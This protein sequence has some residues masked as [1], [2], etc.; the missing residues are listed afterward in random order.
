[1]QRRPLVVAHRGGAL[2]APEN[3]LHAFRHGLACG[4]Q[5]LELDLR[6]TVDGEIGVL[7]DAT[8]DR[9]TDGRGP[10]AER[11]LAEVRLLDAAHW[12]VPGRGAHRGAGPY[13]LR[14]VST[15]TA[16]SPAGVDP[17]ELRV[18]TLD[19]VL[20]AFPGSWVTMEL[21]A[22]DLH[23]RLAAILRAHDRDARVIVG[24]FAA[25]RLAAFRRA[26]PRVATSASEAEVAC[27]W[28][29]VH[30][31]GRKPDSMPYTA[32][33]LPLSHKGTAVVTETLVARAHELDIAVHVW[34][35]D[36]PA[37]MQRFLDLGVDGIMTDRPSVLGRV[38]AER[39]S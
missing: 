7:H 26:A 32:L 3:T 11:A 20:D 8:L 18:P 29:W 13:P 14:G 31:A 4:A 12:F 35:I 25:E 21:K 36:D 15:G 6:R 5:M 39:A 23:D 1:M 10:V 9:T 2:E 17:N 38:L 28:A 27:F 24:A 37:E 19:A 30:G 22:P 16:P 33:Q 34:T